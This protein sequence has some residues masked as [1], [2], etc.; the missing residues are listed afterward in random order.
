[1]KAM[2]GAGIALRLEDRDAVQGIFTNPAQMAG[3]QDL[4]L[5]YV[6]GDLGASWDTYTSLG[7]AQAAFDD[8]TIDKLNVLMGKNIYANAQYVGA[9]TGPNFGAAVLLDAQAGFYAQNPSYPEYTVG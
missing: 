6:N 8:F 5:H 4:M 1:M 3:N 2:G 9:I 7:D